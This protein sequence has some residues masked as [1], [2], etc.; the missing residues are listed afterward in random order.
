MEGNVG[1]VVEH[2]NRAALVAERHVD[3]RLEL[4][5]GRVVRQQLRVPGVLDVTVIQLDDR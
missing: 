3:R 4:P 5:R 2:N 1:V